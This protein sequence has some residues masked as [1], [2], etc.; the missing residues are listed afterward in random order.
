MTA[1][2]SIPDLPDECDT[3]SAA[4]LYAGA[5]WYVGPCDPSTKHP[6]SVLGKGWQ[7][8]TSTDTQ[9]IAAW[10]AGSSHG[11][12]LHVGRSGGLVLD[13]DDYSRLPDLALEAIDALDPPFQSTRDNDLR[14]GHYVFAQP[15]GRMIGNGTGALGKGWGEVRGRN[16]VVVVQPTPH[17]KASTGG[18]YEW[19]RTGPVPVSDAL[20]D[21]LP[22][23]SDS[24][25]PATDAAVAAFLAEHTESIRPTLLQPILA[26]FD[27]D[28]A[29]GGA[30][31]DA[32]RDCSI[33]ACREAR[34]GLFPA[35]EAMKALWLRFSRAMKADPVPGR[36][37]AVEFRGV[38]AWAVAQALLTDPAERRREVED[39]LV[40]VEFMARKPAPVVDD[41]ADNPAL[42]KPR[43]PAAYFRDKEAGID[44][45]LLADDVLARGP[46]RLGR[47]GLF[48]RYSGGVWRE[49]RDE[50]RHRV[51][52]CLAGRYRGSHA[53]NCEHV[54]ARRVQRIDCEPVRQ[55]V[56]LRG[57][58][59]G[60]GGGMLDW[61]TGEVHPHSPDHLSTVQ[62]PVAWDPEATCPRF[63]HFMSQVL[64]PEAVELAWEML[65][66]LMLS[67]N[68][69]QTA[70]LFFG[71]GSNGKGTLMRV[72]TAL[73]GQENCSSVSLDQLN[74]NRF[75]PAALYGMTANIAGDVD[76]S[77]QESTA[78]L[79][80]LTGEDVFRGENKHRDGFSFVSWAVPL[81]SA[82][83]VPGS[84]DTSQ[85]YLRRWTVLHFARQFDPGETV[86]GLSDL[87]TQ[88]LDG[89]AHKAVLALRTL[90][91][92]GAF[93]KSKGDVAAAADEF[94]RKIDQV[95]Q[96][97][98]AT[99]ITARQDGLHDDE[100]QA[101]AT[102]RELRTTL[103]TS[104]K[105]WHSMNNPGSRCMSAEKFYTRLA[106]L[107]GVTP[108]KVQGVRFY[109]GL[110]LV[111]GRMQ[112]AEST[113]GLLS[114][115]EDA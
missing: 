32:L 82:N 54:V 69:L 114:V 22:D 113:A 103:F 45:A 92:R 40:E 4:L 1:G 19:Q 84:A 65:G 36:F 56:N 73:L 35:S 78:A 68:P 49:A 3:L 70:F 79:K 106:A 80:S 41:P 17:E 83:E 14:R 24:A 63:D 8:Q 66:Y 11:L 2:L 85:G 96:W 115:G 107:P 18:R 30:R 27:G 47:D 86:L 29:A 23:A 102:N 90:M 26:K 61:R 39:R 7:E 98:E 15:D 105:A 75:A 43:D 104:Y 20:C 21:A 53:T 57:G 25:D 87:L 95:R 109:E 28:V 16:G 12:F 6:G 51:V 33:W 71:T 76:A 10:F 93:D 46:L 37:P 48:W 81:F 60:A 74:G 72:I 89:I 91:D 97:V 67:G 100:R 94:A 111:E 38:F 112:P 34:A 62:L 64:S 55:F 31:H 13:V 52:D 9:Q 58:A 50:V 44:V 99:C 77:Y 110:R 88:E 101:V 59:D 5:G 42:P 108:V